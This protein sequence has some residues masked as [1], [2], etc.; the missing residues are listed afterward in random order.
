[1]RPFHVGG[2]RF[3][4]KW[5]SGHDML[6][7]FLTFRSNKNVPASP[8]CKSSRQ[9]NLSVQIPTSL[10]QN[11][12]LLSSSTIIIAYMGKRETKPLSCLVLCNLCSPMKIRCCYSPSRSMLWVLY[13]LPSMFYMTHGCIT[14]ERIA[15][16]LIQ[17]TFNEAQ[18]IVPASWGRSDNFCSWER[19]RCNNDSTRVL[20]LN[21]SNM[22]NHTVGGGCLNLNMA[23]FAAFHEL[24][25]L[26]LSYNYACLEVFDGND[27]L[28]A[29]IHLLFSLLRFCILQ[30][31]IVIVCLSEISQG[32]KA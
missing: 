4:R 1:M 21:F 11:L 6:W 3:F 8:C 9:V 14:E 15:L 23:I 17:S 10:L 32:S 22:A 16:R 7:P 25:M 31:S 29:C 20:D 2:M 19:V 12:S 24:Q 26:D 27:F 28:H 13:M 5:K 18:Y 30:G